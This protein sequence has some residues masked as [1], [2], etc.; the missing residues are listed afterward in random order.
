MGSQSTLE[1][2]GIAARLP[3]AELHLAIEYK[4]DVSQEANCLLRV[5]RHELPWRPYLVHMF[6]DSVI[7]RLMV[8][9]KP[10]PDT[11][12]NLF[13]ST[14]GPAA[15]EVAV[16]NAEVERKSEDFSDFPLGARGKDACAR[17]SVERREADDSVGRFAY[18][19]QFDG[20]FVEVLEPSG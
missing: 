1:A 9:G 3:L 2:S 15:E 10:H 14:I 19:L 5:L 12:L 17:I 16:G 20:Q 11:E 7:L 4:S 13:R 8:F 6:A 18:G